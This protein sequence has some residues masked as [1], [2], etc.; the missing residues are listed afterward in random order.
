MFSLKRSWDFSFFFFYFSQHVPHKQ[1]QHSDN[2]EGRD[3][4]FQVTIEELEEKDLVFVVNQG[5]EP[6]CKIVTTYAT[7]FNALWM[8]VSLRRPAEAHFLL[9]GAATE[10]R[11]CLGLSQLQTLLGD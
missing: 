9:G 5:E 4:V 7:V 3:D 1:Q 6:F 8:N 11:P 2:T 10:S